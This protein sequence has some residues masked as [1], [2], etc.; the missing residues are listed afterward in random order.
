MTM[1]IVYALMFLVMYKAAQRY[2][3]SKGY[4]LLGTLFF[5]LPTG[6]MIQRPAFVTD[7]PL[8]L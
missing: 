5:C 3:V 8:P 4:V 1:F 6:F 2:Q 7:W